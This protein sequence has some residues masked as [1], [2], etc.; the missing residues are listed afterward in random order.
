MKIRGSA[1][2]HPSRPSNSHGMNLRLESVIGPRRFQPLRGSSVLERT[3]LQRALKQV[4]SHPDYLRSD[5]MSVD[6]LPD[7][8]RPHWV[9]IRAQR[10]A[11]LSPATGTARGHLE[12]RWTQAFTRYPPGLDRLIPQAMAQGISAQW[13]P[14]FYSRSDG[15]RPGRSA[16][17]AGRAAV[18]GGYPRRLPVSGGVRLG[19]R[20]STG[21]ITTGWSRGSDATCPT[22]RYCAWS[23]ASL[24]PGYTQEAIRRRRPRACRKAIDQLKAEGRGLTRRTCGYRLGEVVAELREVL[25]GRNAYFGIRRA[26]PSAV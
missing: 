21:S 2:D 25:L 5:G 16:H 11:A 8:L 19:K 24:R 26:E 4:R 7:Y 15:F 17:Q 20:S 12:A 1:S 22:A 10:V 3:N 23:T 9:D 6:A 13:E 14:H 18:A